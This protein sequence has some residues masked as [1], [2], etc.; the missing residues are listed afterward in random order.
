MSEQR[1]TVAEIQRAVATEFHVRLD[2][3]GSPCRKRQLVRPRQVAMYLARSLTPMS[4]PE[5]GR[6]FGGRHHTTVLHA[7]HI[8]PALMDDDRP[9][10]G[11]VARVLGAL[12]GDEARAA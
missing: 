6:R 10:C 12:R 7:C 3:L 5:I 8:V 4:L 11:S 2:D 1:V 9:L